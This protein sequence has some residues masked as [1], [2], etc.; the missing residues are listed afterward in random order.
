MK[1]LGLGSVIDGLNE[2][3]N[4]GGTYSMGSE[5]K[6]NPI[7][8]IVFNP[9]ASQQIARVAKARNK[10]TKD[11]PM[12]TSSE[13]SLKELIRSLGGHALLTFP[14]REEAILFF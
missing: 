9:D 12:G 11:E 7:N 14:I 5:L 1:S 2:K 4:A 6:T 13:C 10:V 8:Q 3:L